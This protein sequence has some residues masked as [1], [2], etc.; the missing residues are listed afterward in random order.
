M[1]TQKRID[2]ILRKDI[3]AKDFYKNWRKRLVKIVKLSEQVKQE[4][5]G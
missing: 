4:K 5:R 3:L 2:R 1:H